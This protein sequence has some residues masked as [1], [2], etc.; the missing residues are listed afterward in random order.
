MR[1]NQGMKLQ[2]YNLLLI[3]L[4]NESGEK[5]RSVLNYPYFWIKGLKGTDN[6]RIV[7]FVKSKF[8]SRYNQDKKGK[9]YL[10]AVGVFSSH[11]KAMEHIVKNN[12]KNTIILEDDSILKGKLPNPLKLPQ[13]SLTL[14]S[15]RIQPPKSWADLKKFHSSCSAQK[16]IKN[17]K[18]GVNEIN[19]NDHR[20][21]QQNAVYYPNSKVTQDV[22][23]QIHS[24]KRLKNIDLF[25][26]NPS[27]VKYL[28]Y[29]AP[30]VHDD[31]KADIGS[32]ISKKGHGKIKDYILIEPP[33]EKGFQNFYYPYCS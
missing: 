19:Y 10:G 2:G 11:I 31:I 5:R 25:F 1:S 30:F 33:S 9:G 12:L 20:W 26:N 13:D 3:S 6:N 16:I 24:A 14:F 8:Y 7:N 17:F 21:T 18:R 28:Y 29:P 23:N 27:I 15:G 32:Q 22:L 4:N